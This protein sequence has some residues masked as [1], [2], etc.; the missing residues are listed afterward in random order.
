M[1]GPGSGPKMEDRH[2]GVARQL[3]IPQNVDDALVKAAA[4]HGVTVP[5]LATLLIKRGLT[6]LKP[7][8]DVSWFN[9]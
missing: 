8:E 2:E 9:D 6:H 5:W 7:P 3:R 1:G 4:A